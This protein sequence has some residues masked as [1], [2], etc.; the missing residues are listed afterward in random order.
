MIEK[1]VVII[2]GGPA[3]LTAALYSSR[4]LLK[5]LL[6]E[7]ALIGGQIALSEWIENYPGFPDGISTQEL[8]AR[9]QKQA[10]NFG[11][12]F[13]MDEV[14]DI[15]KLDKGFLIKT[16]GEEIKTLGIVMTT[17]AVPRKLQIPGEEEF[18]GRGISYCATCDGPF[19]KDK[20]VAVVGGGDTA[21]EEAMYLTKHASKVYL[22]HRRDQLRAT[23]ILQE[24][25]RK[26]EKIEFIY[27]ALPQEIKGD[28]KVN[29][30]IYKDKIT[31]EIK[32][33][34]VSGVFIFVGTV[35]TTD[36]L[37]NTKLDI[38]LDDKGYIVV[39]NNLQTNI[40]GI[41]AAGDVIKKSLYQVATAIGEGAT[42]AF[43]LQ[44]YIEE[45]GNE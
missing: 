23:K 15:E 26:N 28:K 6:V 24:R 27:N 18:T 4:A 34:P 42:A 14:T 7:K 2:G 10:E 44:K 33:L 3:G 30:I 39:D 41:F 40:K 32:E 16:W 37:K 19:F 11:A 21:V 5:T 8:V 1:E 25:A 20:E 13:M 31:G 38:A 17:G 29:A 12:E 22:M 36:F 35:P 45:I 9:M 43:N